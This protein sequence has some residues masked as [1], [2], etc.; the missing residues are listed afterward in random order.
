MGWSDERF[1]DKLPASVLIHVT[2]NSIFLEELVNVS[3]VLYKFCS[4]KNNL[5]IRIV[6]P[7]RNNIIAYYFYLHY[8]LL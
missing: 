6:N 5:V 8:Y 3:F 4:N 2:N 7:T 1:L